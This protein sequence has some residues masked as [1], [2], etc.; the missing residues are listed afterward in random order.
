MVQIHSPRLQVAKQQT[1]SDNGEITVKGAAFSITE[2]AAPFIFPFRAP[3]QHRCD[4]VLAAAR[5][6]DGPLAVLLGDE[7]GG[8]SGEAALKCDGVLSM[9]AFARMTGIYTTAIYR[10]FPVGGWTE[11][12]EFA[13][14]ERHPQRPGQTDG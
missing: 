13:G 2:N 9:R 10:L 6:G 14:L 11:V 5:A 7:A 12:R 1:A 4:V 3:P 8:R